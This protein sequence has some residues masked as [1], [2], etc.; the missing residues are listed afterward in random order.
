MTT[1]IYADPTPGASPPRRSSPP[2]AVVWSLTS[3]NLAKAKRGITLRKLLAVEFV[4]G[5]LII[6]KPTEV[7]A[8]RIFGPS[9]A[10]MH[11]AVAERD[12]VPPLPLITCSF[13]GRARRLHA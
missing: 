7:L 12:I 3:Q 8:A 6:E 11:R 13:G 9:Q 5:R 10:A 2:I 1:T 4:H